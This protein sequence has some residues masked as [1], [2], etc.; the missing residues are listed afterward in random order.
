MGCDFLTFLT[1]TESFQ[2]GQVLVPENHANPNGKRIHIS[3][4]ILPALQPS[5]KRN[6]LIYLTGG[7]GGST[8]TKNRITSWLNHPARKSRDIIM[9]DQRGIGY[10]SA[11]PNMD[12]E[13][14]DLMARDLDEEEELTVMEGIIEKYKTLCEQSDINPAHYNSFQNANDVGA[15][16]QALG[17]D[18]YNLYGVSYGTRLA[19]IVQDLFPE[20]IHSVIHN[21]PAPLG[22]D[23]LVD[24]LLAYNQALGNVFT[25]CRQNQECNRRYPN[26]EEE[27]LTTIDRLS[28]KP[29][30]LEVQNRAFTINAQDAIYLLRRKLYGND[31]RTAI[32]TMIEELGNGG[33]PILQGVLRSEMLFTTGYN[34][35]MWLSVER[36]EMFDPANTHEVLEKTYQSLDLL[37]VKLGM[38][39]AFY[40]KGKEFHSN[41]LDESLKTFDISDVPTLI[42]VNYYDPVT[43]PS[44]GYQFMK[45]LNHGQL[46]ILDEGGHGGGSP[47]CRAQVMVDFMDDPTSKPDV[48]CFKIFAE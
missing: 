13:L 14:F 24:R 5:A 21:S 47:A 39:N 7:P 44:F 29:L 2:C 23:F 20:R 19:R 10:S 17:Y 15:V 28:E 35:T 43:P 12:T 18:K 25:Y 11:M 16:M 22:G 48:S 46:Y 9:F 6:P 4:I 32:P 31:S 37:P 38:F 45:K 30:V 3:Y 40:V 42:T 34:S 33:G 36:Y 27:Y 1:N 8:L 26:L 41:A